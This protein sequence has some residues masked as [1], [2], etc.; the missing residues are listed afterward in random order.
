MIDFIYIDIFHL[1][2]TKSL[3]VCL[4]LFG[5]YYKSLFI[6]TYFFIFKLEIIINIPVL[7]GINFSDK[8]LIQW[9]QITNPSSWI[10]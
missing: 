9:L 4:P 1:T 3:L 2:S 5:R 8:L 10:L 6:G 7:P